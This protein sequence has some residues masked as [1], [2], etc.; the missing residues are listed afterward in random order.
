MFLQNKWPQIADLLNKELNEKDPTVYPTRFT[1]E[2]CNQKERN[3]KT[4]YSKE[5]SRRKRVRAD[6]CKTGAAT[7][8]SL[9]E[10]GNNDADGWPLFNEYRVPSSLQA[11]GP[12]R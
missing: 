4:N 9:L 12:H 5:T 6:F 8:L 10:V 11:G 1:G 2:Q 3:M 7:D